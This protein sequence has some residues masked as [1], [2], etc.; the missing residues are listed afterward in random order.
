L[1]RPDLAIQNRQIWIT[2]FAKTE[3]NLPNSHTCLGRR[4]MFA[5]EFWSRFKWIY[6]LW[7]WDR[8]SKF[9]WG[10]VSKLV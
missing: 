9:I 5:Y 6:P 8:D 7:A 10:E 3:G 2:G 1:P 4:T